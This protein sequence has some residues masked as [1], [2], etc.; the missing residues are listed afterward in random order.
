MPTSKFPIPERACNPMSAAN[1]KVYV[2][3]LRKRI[4]AVVKY[5]I[6]RSLIGITAAFFATVSIAQ[7]TYQTGSF[8]IGQVATAAGT[9]MYFRVYGVPSMSYCASGPTFAYVDVS[10]SGYQ[11]KVATLL[12]AYSSGKQI[13]MVV[14]PVDFYGNGSSYCH[15]I[16]IY[17]AP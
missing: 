7:T 15:I 14:Q 17:T 12:T 4:G 3:D 9:N 10:D 2:V 16:E 13:Y 11:G 5:F 1:R 8:V 6:L